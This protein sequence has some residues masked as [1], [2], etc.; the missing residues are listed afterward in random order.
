M[1]QSKMDGDR[2]KGT[3]LVAVVFRFEVYEAESDQEFFL[4]L[5][6]DGK[7][8]ERGVQATV[9]DSFLRSTEGL[10]ET[11]QQADK[12]TLDD[13]VNR[14]R[15]WLEEHGLAVAKESHHLFGM[16]VEKNHTDLTLK[17]GPVLRVSA[18]GFEARFGNTGSARFPVAH[19]AVN[20]IVAYLTRRYGESMRATD[21]GPVGVR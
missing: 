8:A 6:K 1:D 17:A 13:R 11:A 19:M 5:C 14:A 2:T 16:E 9:Y 15:H 12:E 4:R 20:L 10:V 18:G 21:D 7:F 3:R